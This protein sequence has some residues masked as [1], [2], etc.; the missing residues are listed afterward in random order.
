MDHLS[1]KSDQYYHA[2]RQRRLPLFD[3]QCGPLHAHTAHPAGRKHL[4]CRLKTHLE[5]GRFS[6]VIDGTLMLA[7]VDRAESAWI[8]TWILAVVQAEAE[9]LGEGHSHGLPQRWPQEGG[10]A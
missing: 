1:D 5:E 8:F 2:Q 6:K 7:G 4:T 3:L 9:R 10:Q